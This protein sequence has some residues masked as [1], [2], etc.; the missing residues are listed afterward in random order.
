MSIYLSKYINKIL[1]ARLEA[2]ECLDRRY[3]LCNLR[4]K[5]IQNVRKSEHTKKCH[6]Q[7][8]LTRP[9]HRYLQVYN[10]PLSLHAEQLS[11]NTMQPFSA[12]D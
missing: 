10:V 5:A 2:T 3:N 8:H 7:D 12:T 6:I 9:K 4:F 1:C 11:A